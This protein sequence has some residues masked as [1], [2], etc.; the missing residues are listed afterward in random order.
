MAILQVA[1]DYKTLR[2]AKKTARMVRKELYGLEYYIEA[3]TPLIK[4][5]GLKRVIPSLSR[6]V[7]G[8]FLD[9]IAR[10]FTKAPKPRIVADLKTMDT[11]ELEFGIAY[12]AGADIIGI[13]GVAP[14]KTITDVF[15]QGLKHHE[16]TILIDSISVEKMPGREDWLFDRMDGHVKHGGRV[17][18]EYHVPKD[19]GTKKRDYS[20][21]KL[22]RDKIQDLN[23]GI[24]L[25]AAGELNAQT[26]PG[27]VDYLDVVVVGSAITGHKDK[28]DI[29]NA[30]RVIRE[31]ID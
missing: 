15:K 28:K 13:A 12:S 23:E 8:G 10:K 21:V 4:N 25:A 29:R 18:Y 5:E 3:G 20:H 1:L 7:K 2:P 14:D 11:G 17:I 26:I 16:I 6:E 24:V 9:D 22:I 19:W 27:I 31:I 30:I